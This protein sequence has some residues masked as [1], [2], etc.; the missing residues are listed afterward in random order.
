VP[1][2]TS[3]KPRACSAAAKAG[4]VGEHLGARR[5]ERRARRPAKGGARVGEC[6]ASLPTPVPAHL[7]EG[8]RERCDGV[9]ARPALQARE[10]GAVDARPEVQASAGAAR[11]SRAAARR[12]LEEDLVR[13]R[14]GPGATCAS[15]SL[16]CCAEVE[17]RGDHARRNEARGRAPCRT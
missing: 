9:V 17:G 4:A 10:H 11:A 16:R 1:P 15:S 3:V 14:A 8:R 13:L 7:L 6:A 2:D 5:R 12:A